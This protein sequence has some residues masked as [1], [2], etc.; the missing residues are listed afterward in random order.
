M[1]DWVE[2]LLGITL[3]VFI[4]FKLLLFVPWALLFVL[5][6]WAIPYL[7]DYLKELIGFGLFT[8][9]LAG[10]S[11]LIN[12]QKWRQWTALVAAIILYFFVFFKLTFYWEYQTKVSV[13]AMFVIFETN[14]SEASDFLSNYLDW[15]AVLLVIGALFYFYFAAKWLKNSRLSLTTITKQNRLIQLV[16]FVLIAGIIA[17]SIFGIHWKFPDENIPYTVVS[18]FKDYKQTKELLKDQLAQPTGLDVQVKSYASDKAT[19]VVVIGESTTRRNLQL[20]GYDRETN[21]KLNEI[22]QELLVFDSVISP[23]V[24]TITALDKI[25]TLQSFEKPKVDPNVSIVQL[26]NQ[27]GYNTYWLSN[28]RAVGVFESIPTIIGSGAN[29]RFFLNGNAYNDVAH[30]QVLLPTYKEILQDS[31]DQK[32]IFV[33]LMGTHVGYDKRYPKEFDIFK[34][35]RKDK[36]AAASG[37]INQYDNAIRY[38][39]WLLR[40]FIEELRKISGEK[41]LL[42]FSDH[43]DDVFDQHQAIGHNEF[44]ATRPM[45]EVPFVLWAPNPEIHL[46]SKVIDVESRP[47]SLDD[48]E[49]TY[50][51]LLQ[52]KFTGYDATKSVLNVSFEPKKRIIQDTIDYDNW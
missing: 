27:A 30:D 34:G 6:F 13:S 45:Y 46:Y 28:Q 29:R 40:E 2:N 5:G 47:Y 9:A 19:F 23:H 38:N 41:V 15:R 39:D 49:H 8:L 33:H 14:G 51:D 3:P 32:V 7:E 31:S 36:D 42:Y 12:S 11:L 18:S 50:A 16:R 17:G 20:Y 21:P 35:Q 24:H 25:M 43:G 52:F 37:Y 48:F 44:K 1:R 4:R 26:A 10:V 22:K